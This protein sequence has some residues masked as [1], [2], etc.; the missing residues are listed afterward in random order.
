M[1]L[2]GSAPKAPK[3]DLLPYARKTAQR[4]GGLS[5]W[6]VRNKRL[7]PYSGDWVANLTPGQTSAIDAITQRG[8][9][10]SP[11]LKG[12]QGYAGDVLGG[13]Y[14][15][16]GNPYLAQAMASARDDIGRDVGGA[17]S[18]GGMA[19]SPMHQQF[20]TEAWSKATAPLL[21]QNYE[22]ERQNQQQMA[23]LSP[24]LANADFSGLNQALGAQSVVQQQG[25]QE[26]DAKR[27]AWDL[28]QS[29]PYRR[30]QAA[31]G[32]VKDGPTAMVEE[33]ASPGS[34]GLVPGILQGAMG[35]GMAG[36]SVGGGWGAGGGAIL[37]GLGGGAANK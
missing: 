18:T 2:F 30:A 10:G 33:G 26:A 31:M 27:Q 4:A 21:F 37:G 29:E 7:T 36:G 34:K 16:A 35:G 32:V 25:Q 23:G 13:K 15:G 28:Q 1:G 5:A 3:P 22:N 6:A 8:M 24:D 20:L 11:L 12:A 14:L 9:Q 17:F 19:G